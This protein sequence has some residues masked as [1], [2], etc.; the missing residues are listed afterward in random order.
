M[1]HRVKILLLAPLLMMAA[2]SLCAQQTKD[3]DGYRTRL[4]P[5]PSAAAAE[6]RGLERQR[7]M[8]PITEWERPEVTTLRA[9]FTFPFS[10]LERQVYLRVEDSYQPY[11]LYV[12]G[13]LA[14][15]SRNGFA[16]AEYNVT[17]LSREDLNDVEIRLLSSDEVNKIQCFEHNAKT[18]KVYVVSQPRVRVRDISWGAEIGMQGVVNS[19]F[20][21]VMHN[22]TL[23]DKVSTLY[24]EL[25]L[26][27]TIR[28]GAGHRDVALG[29]YGIDTMRFGVAV[30]DSVLW[31]GR[32]P[33]SVRLKLKNRVEGRDVEFYDFPV[34]LMQLS[35]DKG[36][37]YINNQAENIEFTELSP[38]STLEQVQ[39]V[40]E[41]GQRNIRFSAGCVADEILDYCDAEGVYV[42]L[43]APINSSSS[44]DSRRRGGNPSNNPKWR[45]DYIERTLQLYYTTKR[46]PS[47]VAYVLA[48]DSSNGICLYESYLALKAVVRNRPVFYFDGSSEWNSDH[49]K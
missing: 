12:N 22:A 31:S 48:D 40:V 37:F 27:D 10:W 5:Y 43:T 46:H 16:A 34:A 14:G 33:Q 30:P 42:A 49:L 17:K 35:Y 8:Q 13:K 39:K 32:N 7:Y 18:P 19:N 6:A 11:E 24:Y 36:V 1:R 44:G 3:Y 21:V 28:L 23:G 9:K 4:I 47:V 41:S 26:N 2:Q 20:E 29:K 45:A 38:A 25:F 15:S